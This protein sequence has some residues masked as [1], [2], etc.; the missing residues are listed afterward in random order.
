VRFLGLSDIGDA[1]FQLIPWGGDGCRAI[2]AH[3]PS[4]CMAE[5]D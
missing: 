5:G 4:E 3:C 1:S 2:V